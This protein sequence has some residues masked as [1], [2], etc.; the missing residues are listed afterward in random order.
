MSLANT[1][2]QDTVSNF[3]GYTTNKQARQGFS[4]K[5]NPIG[6]PDFVQVPTALIK[7]EQEY[8]QDPAIC[9]TPIEYPD[10]SD[11]KIESY[12]SELFFVPI[13]QGVP[14][15]NLPGSKVIHHQAGHDSAQTQAIIERA[16]DPSYDHRR[17]IIHRPSLGESETIEQDDELIF[18]DFA[19]PSE[20][21][22]TRRSSVVSA[23]LSLP[24]MRS[25]SSSERS[26]RSSRPSIDS[27]T[28]LVRGD[29]DMTRQRYYAGLMHDQTL[30]NSVR[31]QSISMGETQPSAR[32][33]EPY[34]PNVR[35]PLPNTDRGF[36]APTATL[37]QGSRA[38]PVDAIV[39]TNYLEPV[40]SKRRRSQSQYR[41]ARMAGPRL[42]DISLYSDST[43]S[44]RSSSIGSAIV[45][46]YIPN[47][48]PVARKSAGFTKPTMSVVAQAKSMNP[49]VHVNA[50]AKLGK[51]K[52]I[53]HE[54]D[55]TQ[56]PLQ[57]V[58]RNQGTKRKGSNIDINPK[59]QK[60]YVADLEVVVGNPQQ[61]AYLGYP[62]LGGGIRRNTPLAITSS[63]RLIPETPA[64]ISAR[65]SASS[66]TFHRTA[67]QLM[68][69]LRR[70]D[71]QS[72][73]F[74]ARSRPSRQNDSNYF[75][76]IV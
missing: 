14:N 74:G 31:V 26:M 39:N 56:R 18:D 45:P 22:Q 67:D 21:S 53:G 36:Q 23:R 11:K 47:P 55:D 2:T 57:V 71:S 4:V 70:R 9:I 17:S 40:G 43:V 34:I 46:E 35:R 59:R 66:R 54:E 6:S 42:S 13:G 41:N 29:T 63:S 33:S 25:N 19:Y 65:I 68:Q 76:D 3:S 75:D 52:R 48:R 58:K 1:W 49:D 7:A 73:P 5:G 24:S 12:T 62:T 15:H 51:R 69:T 37:L 27:S 8:L 72:D 38:L 60:G 44:S 61:Q 64:E 16:Q 20:T 30:A 10:Y 32:V 50:S 28:G